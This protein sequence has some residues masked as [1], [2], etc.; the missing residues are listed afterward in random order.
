M[1]KSERTEKIHFDFGERFVRTLGSNLAFS[2]LAPLH[3]HQVARARTAPC[4]SRVLSSSPSS[5]L[6]L[7]GCFSPKSYPQKD[8]NRSSKDFYFSSVFHL[9]RSPR[10]LSPGRVNCCVENLRFLFFFYSRGL[11]FAFN[12]NF[13]FAL[14]LSS[15]FSI[16]VFFP[17][18]TTTSF[19]PLQ[20]LS[21][22]RINVI[23]PFYGLFGFLLLLF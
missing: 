6:A 22:F 17:S 12:N 23:D 3:R 20:M 18:T 14:L 9:S 4:V 13:F 15:S 16:A 1:E 8:P 11:C 7:F 21:S 19:V 2:P 5:R 10:A